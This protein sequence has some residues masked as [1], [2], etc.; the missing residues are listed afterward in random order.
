M[1]TTPLSPSEIVDSPLGGASSIAGGRYELQ[2]LIGRGPLGLVYRA[3]DQELE[4]PVAIKCI[5]DTGL[6]DL[7]SRVLAEAKALAAVN[8]QHVAKIYD[9]LSDDD[10]VFIV[11]EWFE[12]KHLSDVRL[13]LAPSVGI[14]LMIQV[15][16][17]L[18]A[19]HQ[20]DLPHRGLSAD[21]VL[22]GQQGQVKLI[23]FGGTW[24]RIS[25]NS[26]RTN[27]QQRSGDRS[28]ASTEQLDC[29]VRNDLQAAE[30]LMHTV[31]ATLL[32][33]ASSSA[34]IMA[35]DLRILLATLTD[36]DP[37][38]HIR[39]NLRA[40]ESRRSPPS[41]TKGVDQ[42]LLPPDRLMVG[43]SPG[44][45][46]V[47]QL[48][49]RLAPVNVATLIT[50]ETGTGKELVAREIHRLSGR[51]A[52]P[53]ITVNAV[54]MPASLV[55]SELFGHRRGAFTGAQNDR[56][57]LIE[58]ADGGTLFLDEIGELS[59]E[60]QAKLLRVLQ[61]RSFTRIGDNTPRHSDFRLVTATH[62]NLPELI[63][64]GKF[65]E[66]LYYRIAAANIQMPPLRERREDIAPL[67]LHF[68][69]RF[70]EEHGLSPKRWSTSALHF[71]SD[72]PWPGNIRQL[73]HCV[74]RALVMCDGPLV[75]PS[76]LDGELGGDLNAAWKCIDELQ[77][78]TQ[79]TLDEAR[80][81]WM[82]RFL[83]RAL[84]KHNGR[85]SDTA[86]ALGIGERTLF[87]YIEQFG[88]T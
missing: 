5:F 20:V 72:L 60:I 29:A 24:Q 85:R 28:V 44:L 65:R 66:D 53:L 41:S 43:H 71:L 3:I 87:R 63:A 50:G 14:A 48:I 68:H 49:T 25:A 57:G 26:A 38:T 61:E 51:A 67:V 84:A 23:G 77:A 62:R 9:V 35:K 32:G 18:A 64:S 6:P 75:Q 8:D 45:L 33:R 30:H 81:A 80:N 82:R 2:E 73:E 17:G 31:G 59:P 37:A 13:P 54:A 16:E 70:T 88:I 83:Q 78:V 21:Q 4:R 69:R 10:R 42:P 52:G 55:E 79:P 58:K 56:V 39:R 15:Y 7:R 86:K 40:H 12:A 46:A 11:T 47:Y 27:K 36:E 76:H 19:A 74:R 22:V 34:A 1:E